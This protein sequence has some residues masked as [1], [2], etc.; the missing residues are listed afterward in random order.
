[1]NGPRAIPAT[2]VKP[3]SDIGKLR[4]LSPFHTSLILPPTMLIATEDPPP[5][6]NL[7]TTRVAKLSANADPKRDSSKTIYAICLM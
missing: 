5:P 1:M 4:S 7:V 3:K 6:R 2:D